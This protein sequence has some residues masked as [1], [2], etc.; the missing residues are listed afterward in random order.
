MLVTKC[1]NWARLCGL[2]GRINSEAEERPRQGEEEGKTMFDEITQ[3][4]YEARIEVIWDIAHYASI[5][6]VH[7]LDHLD[8]EL[9]TADDLRV[10]YFSGGT[11][12]ISREDIESA[13]ISAS[14]D[15]ESLYGAD[16]HTLVLAWQAYRYEGA[17]TNY[18]A[19]RFGTSV[20]TVLAQLLIDLIHRDDNGEL[21]VI[22]K[23]A[24]GG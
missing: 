14:A 16:I 5:E 7:A 22:V 17:E 6:A 1:P 12:E 21:S 15:A 18:S 10:I 4:M 20:G 9:L 24:L 2:S 11:E 13:I 8:E 19:G 23:T 3:E